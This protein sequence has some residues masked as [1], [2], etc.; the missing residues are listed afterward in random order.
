M[1]PAAE[2]GSRREVLP[3]R[4]LYAITSAALCAEPQRL[5]AGVAAA[6]QG[7]A[8]VIQYRDKHSI[9]PAQRERNVAALLQL[10]RESQAR[11]I[12]ND[13]VELAAR[14]GADGVHLGAADPPLALARARLGHDALIGASCG[15]SLQR[16][17]DAVANGANYLAFGRFF[18]SNTKPDAPQAALELLVQ[19][20]AH[21]NH[22]RIPICAIGG[23]TPATAVGLIAAGADLVAAVE[24]VF[25]DLRPGA[26]TA[27]ARAY[28]ELFESPDIRY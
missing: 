15:P 10:C 14:I 28:A 9:S 3:L 20:R 6:L 5:L 1:K 21:F 26:I 22:L 4:G 18:A 16:G 25:G 12:I 7:G 24:G 23:V 27:A 8:R 11:L 2:S 17:I 19:A 13:D